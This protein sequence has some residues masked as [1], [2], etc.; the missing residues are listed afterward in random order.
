MSVMLH[1]IIFNIN[2]MIVLLSIVILIISNMNNIV[3]DTIL[4]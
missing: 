1:I 3:Y 4:K 2:N